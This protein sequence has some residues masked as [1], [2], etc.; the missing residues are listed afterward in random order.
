MADNW[1]LFAGYFIHSM[2]LNDLVLMDA[3]LVIDDS[4]K[5]A[6]ILQ[7]TNE[8]GREYLIARLREQHEITPDHIIKLDSDEFF[9]PGLIDSHC[10]APQFVNTG[11]GNDLPLLEWLNKYTFPREA[12]FEDDLHAK[13]MYAHLVKRLLRQGTTTCSYYATLHVNATKILADCMRELGQRG[14]VGKVCMDINSPDYYRETAQDCIRDNY[15]IIDY[16][17]DFETVRPVITPRFALSCSSN[18]MKSLGEIAILHGLPIQ[19]HLSESVNEILSVKKLYP[20]LTY[21]QVYDQHNLIGEKTILAHCVHLA[22]DEIELIRERNAGISHCPTS[23]MNLMSGLLDIQ[24]LLGKHIKVG[25]GTDV[26]GGYS[27]SILTA[28]VNTINTSKIVSS[29]PVNLKQAFY[30]AT[31]GNAKVLNFDKQIG[32]FEVGKCFD[33]LLIDTSA[34]NGI[35]TVHRDDRITD[36]FEKFIY[37]GDD[38]NISKVYVNGR[39]VSSIV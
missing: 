4:G 9:I 1:K 26:S 5:I 28:I 19:T 25:L 27:S 18:L 39:L 16:L 36:K 3:V 38:R 33:A 35:I 12:E 11:R 22:S 30:L 17:K 31:L 14:L 37:T 24:I 29:N 6:D 34:E 7:V 23:N 2:S 13:A 8:C 20:S 10:H 21:T 32:N 15:E